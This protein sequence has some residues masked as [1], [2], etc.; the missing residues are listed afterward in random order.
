[1]QKTTQNILQRFSFKRLLSTQISPQVLNDFEEDFNKHHIPTSTFQKLAL[2]IG[3]AA[4]CIMNPRRPEMIACMGESTGYM[5][6]KYMLDEMEKST[7]GSEILRNRPRINSKTVDLDKLKG[8]PEGTLGRVYVDFLK[9]N[10]VT[11]DSRGPVQFVEDINLAYVMQR[12]RE[13]HD[14]VHTI[15]E[16]PTNMI[17]E[18]TVKWV[19]G[20]QTKLPMCVTGAVFGPLRLKP[21]NRDTYKKYYLPWAIRTGN[22]ANLLFNVY[23][24]KRWDQPLYELHKELNINPLIIK[25]EN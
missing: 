3:S 15:L 21:K 10:N 18:I 20:I 4:V 2:G 24:E 7:E 16:M 19:E 1:M 6:M 13:V 14:L 5:A 25:T 9:K 17:G 11:P 23:Y 8:Y 22:E 12:Y